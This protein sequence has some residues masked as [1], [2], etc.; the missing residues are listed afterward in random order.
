M[1][2]CSC[3]HPKINQ[4]AFSEPYCE[5]CKRWWDPRYGSRTP[6][7]PLPPSRLP[8]NQAA[9]VTRLAPAPTRSKYVPHTGAKQL[10]KQHQA[11]TAS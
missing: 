1:E 2:I 4:S 11:A 7:Q 5:L 10:R 3:R 9:H 6:G 8:N